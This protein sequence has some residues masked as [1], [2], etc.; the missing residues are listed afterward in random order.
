MIGETERTT[1]QEIT[2]DDWV[3]REIIPG[4][5]NYLVRRFG[6][7]KIVLRIH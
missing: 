3:L 5:L 2:N 7:V 6:V 4:P 1:E